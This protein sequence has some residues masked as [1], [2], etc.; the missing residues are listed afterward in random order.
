MK[1]LMLFAEARPDIGRLVK[2]RIN[3]TQHE[4]LRHRINFVIW[5]NLWYE[6]HFGIPIIMFKHNLWYN[7]NFF[8][9]S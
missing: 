3:D 7:I 5:H 8:C 1:E 9:N 2:I 6:M 4:F